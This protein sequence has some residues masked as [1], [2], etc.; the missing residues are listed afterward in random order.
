MADLITCGRS[1]DIMC[2]PCESMNKSMVMSQVEVKAKLTESLPRWKSVK[3]SYD[4]KIKISLFFKAKNFQCALNAIN[5]FGQ[6]A[7]REGH[8]PDIH[9]TNY[10][11]VEIF[12]FTHSVGGVTQ[13]D[14]V[15]AQMFDEVDIVYS[16]KWLKE[17]PITYV[18]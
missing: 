18:L 1:N 17:N 14:L 6:I 7:E 8:H 10:R 2:E 15:L 16:P 4:G 12:L 3:S 9:L 11:D 13:N 5:K